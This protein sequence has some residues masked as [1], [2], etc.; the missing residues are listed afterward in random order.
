[1]AGE[2]FWAAGKPGAAGEEAGRLRGEPL[3][4]RDFSP[5]GADFSPPGGLRGGDHASC[6]KWLRTYRKWMFSRGERAGAG[7]RFPGFS[8]FGPVGRWAG[9]G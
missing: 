9:L 2:E 5:P 1:M 8:G 3:G 6:A 4:I 7:A